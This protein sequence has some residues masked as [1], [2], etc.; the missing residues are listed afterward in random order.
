MTHAEG[1][2]GAPILVTATGGWVRGRDR[3]TGA[4]LW[5]VKVA[6]GGGALST[7]HE[8][9]EL[10]VREDIVLA[11]A[12]MDE[13]LYCL[14]YR[15]GAVVGRVELGQI[16][17]KSLLVDG[18]QIFVGYQREIRCYD[19][20]GNLLW[21]DTGDKGAGVVSFGFPGNVRQADQT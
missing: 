13:S 18:D 12:Y 11:A 16:G 2:G 21:E 9:I 4:R 8:A 5:E 19:F 3:R 1:S 7:Y 10:I 6:H 17:R 15:T 20:R 14:D